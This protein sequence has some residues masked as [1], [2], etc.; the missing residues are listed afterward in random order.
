MHQFLKNKIWCWEVTVST[1]YFLQLGIYFPKIHHSK[2]D[3]DYK[4][5]S[6]NLTPKS[7]KY[8]SENE[9]TKSRDH[10]CNS[11]PEIS[12]SCIR[13]FYF[14]IPL[15]NIVVPM[16]RAELLYI[17]LFQ[18]SGQNVIILFCKYLVDFWEWGLAKYFLGL[19]KY[20]I[21]CSIKRRPSL[22]LLCHSNSIQHASFQ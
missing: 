11:T 10:F 9:I 15:G 18:N 2:R 6:P 17:V 21:V 13:L 5:N 22:V 19:H 3:L 1:F 14:I 8:I 16:L 4:K 7:Q 12:I 20:K